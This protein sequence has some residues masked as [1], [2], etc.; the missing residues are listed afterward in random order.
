[1]INHPCLSCGACCA[2]FRVSFHW[3]ETLIES[4]GV[5][6]G[7]SRSVSP[8]MNSMNGTDQEQ[9]RCEA[10]TGVI[11]KNVSCQIYENRPSTC[12][13]FSPSFEDGLRNEGCE[14]ARIK[15]GLDILSRSDWNLV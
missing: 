9:P 11:A 6:F 2:F 14:T 4:F 8:H 10:L 3:S 15:H 13:T 7:A 12:R 5:P 1:M